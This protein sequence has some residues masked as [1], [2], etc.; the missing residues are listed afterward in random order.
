M[1]CFLSVA[2]Q[3]YGQKKDPA[4]DNN[5]LFDRNIRILKRFTW[6]LFNKMLMTIIQFIISNNNASGLQHIFASVE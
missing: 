5:N 4:K 6:I 3:S 1:Q 2:S